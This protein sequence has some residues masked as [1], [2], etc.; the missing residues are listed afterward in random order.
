V[1]L[2]GR[3]QWLA[4]CFLFLSIYER[5]TRSGATSAGN[6]SG[7]APPPPPED[8]PLLL[9]LEDDEELLELLELEEDELELDAAATVRVVTAPVERTI[10][11]IAALPVSAT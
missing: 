11:R 3:F 4:G 7:K 1:S 5:T 9:E 10:L 2:S 8:D 6:Q